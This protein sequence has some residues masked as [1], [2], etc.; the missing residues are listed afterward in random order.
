VWGPRRES[1]ARRKASALGSTAAALILC[2]AASA[3]V[4]G[5]DMLIQTS[6]G[7]TGGTGGTGASALTSPE[8][9]LPPGGQRTAI[10]K[11]SGWVGTCAD[12]ALVPR[13]ELLEEGADTEQGRVRGLC[14]LLQAR[15]LRAVPQHLAHPVSSG[16]LPVVSTD[17]CPKAV[18]CVGATRTA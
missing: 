8:G 18:K 11:C 5:Q 7:G 14:G 16:W 2:L 10:G 9:A 12:G 17:D 4:H 3:P 6:M 15:G 13:R 1:M